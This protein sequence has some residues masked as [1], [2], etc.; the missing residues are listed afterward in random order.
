[1]QKRKKSPKLIDFNESLFDYFK[2]IDMENKI[3]RA[4]VIKIKK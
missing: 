4:K 1:M 3:K 2:L